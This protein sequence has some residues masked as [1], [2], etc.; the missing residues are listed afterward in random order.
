MVYIILGN[1]FEEIEAIAACDILRRGGLPVV[2][3]AAGGEKS[4]TGAHGIVVLADALI[5]N[6]AFTPDDAVVIPGGMGGIKSIRTDKNAMKFIG[7][8]AESGAWL[9]AICA[10]PAVLAQLGLTDGKRITCYPGNEKT[11]GG[12]LCESE[13][14]ILTDGRLVTGRAPGSALD[15][16]LELLTRMKGEKIAEKIRADLVY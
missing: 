4:V 10:G 15:F 1:G 16:A 3:A 7:N 2:L 13:K 12:A 8:A 6:A 9:A 5:E 14:P 11:M